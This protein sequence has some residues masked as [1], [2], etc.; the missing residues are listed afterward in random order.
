MTDSDTSESSECLHDGRQAQH[1]HFDTPEATIVVTSQMVHDALRW[2]RT[3]SAMR[4]E[5]GMAIMHA[6]ASGRRFRRRAATSPA[7]SARMLVFGVLRGGGGLRAGAYFVSSRRSRS[8]HDR[9]QQSDSGGKAS[10]FGD[11]D[12]DE[13]DRPL[14]RSLVPQGLGHPIGLLLGGALGSPGEAKQESHSTNSI[15]H[16]SDGGV[17]ISAMLSEAGIGAG[18]DS[19]RATM[20]S[21]SNMSFC[22][23]RQLTPAEATSSSA[24]PS[25]PLQ[26]ACTGRKAGRRLAR[27]WTQH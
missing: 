3:A 13:H 20:G 26:S 17:A 11:V 9:R 14:I 4:H 24:P 1:T 6:S 8:E 25:R 18:G 22:Q 27:L 12:S 16:G 5:A 10:P 23:G 7:V 15:S 21:F 2:T 19:Y